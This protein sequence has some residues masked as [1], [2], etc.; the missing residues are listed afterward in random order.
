MG[1]SYNL[2]KNKKIKYNIKKFKYKEED[3]KNMTTFQLRDICRKEKLVTNGIDTSDKRVLVRLIM[4]Y[5]GLKK[6]LYINKQNDKGLEALQSFINRVDKKVTYNTTIK[7]PRYINIYKG[8]DVEIFD[9]LELISR[10]K[11]DEGNILLVDD[12]YKICTIFNLVEYSKGRFYLVK[13]REIKVIDGTNKH[14]NLLYFD[15]KYSE[16]IYNIYYGDIKN[17]PKYIKFHQ[18]PIIDFAIK[19]LKDS[20]KPLS[21]DF[22]TT[23]TT[24]GIFS[25]EEIFNSVG[26]NPNDLSNLKDVDIVEVIDNT[27]GELKK[28][29][30]IPSIVGIK[31]IKND[32]A[33]YLFGYDAIKLSK[34][35]YTDSNICIFYD[36]KRWISDYEREERLIDK[37]GETL[38]VKRKHIIDAYINYIIGIAE[39]RFKCKFKKV[40]I[41]CPT[42]QKNRFNRLFKEIAE[43][44][45]IEVYNTLDEGTCV[46]FNTIWELIYKNKYIEDRAYRAL[47]I[48]CGGGTTDLS[49]CEFKIRNNRI[50]YEIDIDT[51]YENGDTDFGGNNLTYRILQLLKM[52]I[53]NKLLKKQDLKEDIFN[54]FNGDLFRIVDEKGIKYIYKY[55]NDQ[56]IKY[57]EVI[58]TKFNDY[59]NKSREDYFKVKDN[60]YLLF[61]LA[62]RVKHY[63][64][65]KRDVLDLII[66]E[67]DN[68]ILDKPFISF[69][70]WKL[71]TYEQMKLI[72]PKEDIEILLNI[73]HI[74]TLLKADIYNIIKKFLES[75]YEENQLLNYSIIKLTGQSCKIDIFKDAI[76]EFVPGR[77]IQFNDNSK[78]DNNH[79]LKLSCLKGSLR[80]LQAKQF[81]HMKVKINNKLPILPYIISA[82]THMGTEKVLIDSLKDKQSVGSISRF[83]DRVTLKL[84]LKDSNGDRRYEYEYENYLDDYERITVEEIEEKYKGIIVQDETDT[85]INNEIK[86]FVW[87]IREQ[88]GFC[89]VPILRKD[90]KLFIGREEFYDFENDNWECNFFDGLK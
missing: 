54:N 27:K 90:E 52:L 61:D 45:N 65:T 42:K 58:P 51:A 66:T 84:Y 88:W 44:Y 69:D 3:L 21:I 83:M 47:I 15:K 73:N 18:I 89:V 25:N 80:Y 38:W 79:E 33:K 57:E 11:L 12:N 36:I 56:Y 10:E 35:S 74:R 55:L 1:Y 77:I 59:I 22:G 31:S 40:H 20:D 16:L 85:I 30:L 87:S 6:N 48:D 13:S 70:K 75:K 5:R 76:K 60:Y 17:I 81:G 19:D 78:R 26:G 62:D 49:S 46:L 72:Q 23:N 63:F 86:F 28:T 64:F 41:S 82:Y 29:P 39:N 2:Y 67:E 71:H 4:K 43:G 9:S 50:S 8:L 32:S 37:T 7:T 68:K 14:Y 34:E 53:G 24:A